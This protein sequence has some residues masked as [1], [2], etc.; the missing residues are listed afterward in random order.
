MRFDGVQAPQVTVE[1]AFGSTSTADLRAAGTF[2]LGESLLGGTDTLGN[3]SWVEV[4]DDV[5][6]L[7]YRGGFD[8]EASDVSP[9]TSTITVEN[10]S[11]VYD[12]TVAESP[13]SLA[14]AYPS[15]TRYPSTGDYPLPAPLAG[16]TD[17]AEVDV[18]K[19]VRV[20]FT[21]AGTSY[22]A[23]THYV[24]AISFDAGF[25][26]TVTFSCVDGLEALGRVELGEIPPSFAGDLPGVRLGRI[27]DLAGWP[28]SQRSLVDGVLTL[29]ET[30]YGGYALPL[31]QEVADTES[32]RIF[33]NPD[34]DF[35][36]YSRLHNYV[37]SRSKTVQA[38]LS[39]VGTDVDMLSLVIVKDRGR[40]Y[41]QAKVTRTGGVEQFAEDPT[42]R[43]THGPRL[44][45]GQIGALAPSDADAYSLASWLVAQ[46]AQ[47]RTEVRQVSIDATVQGMWAA[48]LP[49]RLF[50]RIR[51]VRDYGPV[52]VDRELLIFGFEV[53][54]S[55]DQWTYTFSTV[56][57]SQFTPFFLGVSTLDSV[58]QLA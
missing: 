58:A 42:S 26:P 20:R 30:T 39:D 43:Q 4:T 32:G 49:L 28:T 34:G 27:L 50:D 1:M 54:V 53:S 11:G 35:T 9:G 47:P 36:F 7:T 55:P 19:P 25:E 48:L 10:Y 8:D 13:V 56:D 57:P 52:T 16:P 44:Y 31:A 41:N 6:G 37:A 18:G 51:V 22:T 23:F 5:I 33:I 3:V 29:A 38:T 40:V 2:I 46:Y 14:G 15:P 21:W 45:P 17:A 12:P 24:D